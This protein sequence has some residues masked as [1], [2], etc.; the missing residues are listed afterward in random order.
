MG[1]NRRMW[2]IKDSFKAVSRS[3]LISCHLSKINTFKEVSACS[4]MSLAKDPG[5]YGGRGGNAFDDGT[6][7]VRIVGIRTVNI[8][9]GNQ[10]DSIQ[11]DYV[12]ADGSI[13]KAPLH[14]GEGGDRYSFTLGSGEYICK[15]EGKTNHTIVDQ[16][17]FHVRN[18][19]GATKTYG[20]YGKTGED[21]FSKEGKIVAFHGGAG[22]LLDY[23]GFYDL[24]D[25]A[26][27]LTKS[28]SF[29]GSGGN[30]FDDYVQESGIVSIKS[31]SIRSGNQVDS[32]Q[33]TYLLANGQT[34]TNDR[35]G[36]GGGVHSLVTLNKG[37]YISKVEGKTNGV[38]IDQ[39]LI[40]VTREDGSVKVFGPYGKTGQ[41][42]FK[43]EGNI[44]AF[45]GSAGNLMDSIGFY[46]Y[47]KLSKSK[48][49]GGS[50]GDPFNDDPYTRYPGA[51]LKVSKLFINAGNQVDSIQAEYITLGGTTVTGPR[52]GGEG[53]SPYIMDVGMDE[54]IVKMEGKT[55]GQLIDQLTFT[56][57]NTR[58]KTRT[59]G[60]FGKTGKTP[61]SV[62]A[63][64]GIQG[65][66]G[67]VGNQIDGLGVYYY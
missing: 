44:V 30:M 33:V 61:F 10:V 62:S 64:S 16:L 43:V 21:R 45:F 8:R 27:T 3:L 35:H 59:A 24:E 32:I 51:G 9:A 20:P 25:F 65:F 6:N 11:V 52:L 7:N 57:R 17:T 18:A 66:F 29:G 46:C 47:K 37:D 31:I 26:S 34:K 40:T 1:I 50:G 63:P 55:N 5:T 41:T 58:G 2:T 19:A 49:F 60:P 39:L 15:V 13:F 4:K 14:G 42:P 53:G 67:R 36:G 23:I 54:V 48:M 12:L 28:P 56:M 38:L 22:S